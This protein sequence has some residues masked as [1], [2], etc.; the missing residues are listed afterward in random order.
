MD[1]V[2]DPSGEVK[3]ILSN[4]NTPF[5]VWDESLSPQNTRPD[6]FETTSTMK[7]AGSGQMINQG[8]AGE[9]SVGQSLDEDQTKRHICIQASAKHLVLASPVFKRM[10]AD[11]WKEG[12]TLSEQG[13]V[14]VTAD[15]WDPQVFLIWLKIIHCQHHDVPRQLSLEV[16]AKIAVISDYYECKSVL[17]FFSETWISSLETSIPTKYSRD[18][19]LWMWVCWYFQL[20]SQFREATLIAME[21]AISPIPSLELPIPAIVINTLDKRRTQAIESTISMLNQW[22][23]DLTN[24]SRGCNFECRSMMLGALIKNMHSHDLLS[25]Q[26]KAPFLGLSVQSLRNAVNSFRSPDW[27]CKDRYRN[28]GDRCGNSSFEKLFRSFGVN[29]AGLD[30]ITLPT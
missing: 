5:A 12:A 23:Q 20:R 13:S 1:E 7:A 30:L 9:D 22:Q 24:N 25:P 10:L 29:L 26:P 18:L 3:I 28:H 6:G 8:A 4:A 21:H 19:I 11:G 14:E 27:Y 2:I 16:L 17:G 15:G